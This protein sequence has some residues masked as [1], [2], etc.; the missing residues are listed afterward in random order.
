M[1]QWTYKDQQIRS[2]LLESKDRSE[3]VRVAIEAFDGKL[4]AF[5]YCLGQYDGVAISE[6]PN[7][8][9]ALAAVLAIS[10]MGRVSAM[11]TTA[12]LS[13]DEGL[14]A[15]LTASEKLKAAPSAP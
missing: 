6:F 14:N 15:M 13:V 4:H 1:H 11:Q 10:G 7:S 2:L 8:E 3:V 5:Y 9:T 12:L